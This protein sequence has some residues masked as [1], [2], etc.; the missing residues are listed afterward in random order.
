MGAKAG[1]ALIL[2]LTW[3]FWPTVLVGT[4]TERWSKG[5]EAKKRE[6]GTL[7]R[8]TVAGTKSQFNYLVKKVWYG[9]C[10]NC[11][12]IL[13]PVSWDRTVCPV[14]GTRFGTLIR[15]NDNGKSE[16]RTKG[17]GSGRAGTLDSGNGESKEDGGKP[18]RAGVTEKSV[19]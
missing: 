18:D 5:R 7:S 12:V 2:A 15:R 8:D 16:K 19:P 11:H 3:L 13:E 6:D 17:E 4:A 1:I 14:C 10:P 9:E